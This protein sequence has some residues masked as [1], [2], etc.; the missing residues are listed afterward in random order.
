MARRNWA[1]LTTGRR[2]LP[3]MCQPAVHVSTRLPDG[4]P[5]LPAPTVD[6]GW[7]MADL[8]FEKVRCIDVSCG[9]RGC[10]VG[11]RTLALVL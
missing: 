3:H 1:P 7:Q 11:S 9:R 5:G 8:Y 10:E 4:R 2:P 6:G